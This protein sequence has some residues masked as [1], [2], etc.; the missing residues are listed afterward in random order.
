VTT[1]PNR[2]SVQVRPRRECQFDHRPTSVAEAR[3]FVTDAMAAWGLVN[4]GAE[5]AVSE[6]A[7][8]AVRHTGDRFTVRI[9]EETGCVRVEVANGSS[10]LP[11]VR[12][13][14]RDRE[15]GRGLLLVEA[16]TSAWG[17]VPS[18]GGKTVWF[19]VPALPAS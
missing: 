15:G 10:L 18:S 3:H 4:A 16:V 7:T 9:T 8:N 2:M 6:L 5:L 1:R 14:T 13:A 17:V 19:T 12:Q 11:S